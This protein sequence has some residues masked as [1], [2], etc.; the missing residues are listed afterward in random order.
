[1]LFYCSL[2]TIMR[3]YCFTA[4]QVAVLLLLTAASRV[5]ATS[6]IVNFDDYASVGLSLMPN[7]PGAPVPLASQ[8][9]NQ[10]LA[11]EGL[12]FSS[13]SNYV[14][15]GSF[16]TSS[17]PA[18][19]GGVASNGDLSYDDPTKITFFLPGT[20][21]PAVTDSVSITGD[22]D[23]IPTQPATFSAYDINGVLIAS[24]TKFDIG[25]TN[26]IWTV[27]SPAI[28][29][30]VFSG[31]NQ[32]EP[33]GSGTGIALDDLT[34]DSLIPARRGDANGDGIVDATD[35]SILVSHIG[36]SVSGGYTVGDFNGDGVVNADDF[37]IFAWG[38]VEYNTS[39]IDVPEPSAWYV[40]AIVCCLN[41]R[42]CRSRL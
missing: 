40:V 28:H 2:D 34:F 35:L 10:Y 4:A 9:S 30:V 24:F 3:Y 27:S 41:Q 12:L 1:M 32:G 37:A 17:P 38:V 36:T 26:N 39:I 31:G 11:S 33:Y 22:P 6:V 13:T 18:G 25:G 42:R 29:S 15:I 5:L 7:S 14:A 21:T 23:G 8:L 19:I 16:G 20:S